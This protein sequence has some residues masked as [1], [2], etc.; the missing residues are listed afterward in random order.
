MIQSYETKELYTD[1]LIL[2]KGCSKDC[3]KVYEY[4]LLKCRGI[5]GEE[6]LEKVS[7]PIDFIKEDSELYYKECEENKIYDWFI[8]L[9]NGQVIG[10]I[11]ADRQIEDINSIEIAYNLH[12]DYWKKG[13]MKE[14]VSVVINYLFDIGYDNIISGYDEGNYKSMNLGKKLGFELY[15]VNKNSYKKNGVDIDSYV[16]IL[17]KNDW[18]GRHKVL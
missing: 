6:V 17:N 1:R 18:Y 3:I 13:Y 15:K 10:N 11:T 2:K 9:K 5:A 7:E 16:T 8:Y 14:A 4:D 12:P